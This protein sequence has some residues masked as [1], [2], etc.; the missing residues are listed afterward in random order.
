MTRLRVVAALGIAGLLPVTSARAQGVRITGVTSMQAVDLRPLVDDSVPVGEASGTGPYRARADGR[1]VRCIEGDSYCRF[2]SSGE[3]ELATPLVQD[4]RA[5]AWGLGEGISIHAHVRARSSLGSSGLSWPRADDSF[6]AIEVWLEIDRGA[7]RAR[8]GRQWAT[9]GLGVYNYDGG[10]LLLRRGRVRIE[11]FGGRSLVAGLN[12]PVTGPEL[13]SLDDLP[14]DENGWL[15]G[16]A[17]ST[18]LGTRGAAGATWQRVIRADHAG[19]Y[20]ERIG[21]D[22]SWRAFGASADFSVAWDVSAREVNEARLQVARPL[23]SGLTASVEA[24]RHRPFFEAWTIWGVF[25]PVAFD[26]AR[27]TLAW[28][29]ASGA[30]GLDARGGRRRYDETSG[31]L[32]STPLKDDGWR[33]GAGA[34]WLPDE[35]WLFHADYDVDIGF[36]ASRSDVVAGARWMPDESRWLGVA[37]T[38]LQHIYEF[39]VGTGRVNGLRLEGGT[40]I[41]ADARLVVDAALHAHHQSGSGS[42]PDWS[43]RRF[44]LR[45]EWTVGRDPGTRVT[46]SAP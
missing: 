46:R 9:G 2:R 32:E 7:T 45:L 14:P 18:P 24:R 13:G 31:G 28:R 4:L 43:Q 17:A 22:A 33:A 29:S 25:S 12:E 20:S 10:S 42:S 37:A 5:V 34:E 11:A 36:G 41:G 6:D 23:S 3:R 26:E 1:L 21:A 39:R 30:L 40:R 19:L 15:L 16:L 44:S 27:A 35:R 38:A 8:L